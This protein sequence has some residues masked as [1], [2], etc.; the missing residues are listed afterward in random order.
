MD[1]FDDGQV[2][3]WRQGR[4]ADGMSAIEIEW[5]LEFRRDQQRRA[6]RLAAS[7]SSGAGEPAAG[8]IEE[9]RALPRAEQRRRVAQDWAGVTAALSGGRVRQPGTPL[10]RSELADLEGTL[11]AHPELAGDP[12]RWA[13][14]QAEMTRRGGT[15]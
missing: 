6:A 15:R 1:Y 12:D 8:S 13:E 10:S 11:K 7:A 2:Q 14:I 5:D 4:E 9:L 3:E